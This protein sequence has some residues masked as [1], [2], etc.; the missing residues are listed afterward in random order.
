MGQDL[1][2]RPDSSPR[3]GVRVVNLIQAAAGQAYSG[4]Q[5]QKQER[6]DPASGSGLEVKLSV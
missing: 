1:E 5:Q 3:A 4:H 6:R 2:A